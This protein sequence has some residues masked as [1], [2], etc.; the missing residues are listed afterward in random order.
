[1]S[2]DPNSSEDARDRAAYVHHLMLSALSAPGG[3]R[4]PMAGRLVADLCG[5]LAVEGEAEQVARY[6]APD[7]ADK[8][9]F[10]VRSFRLGDVHP[11]TDQ[12]SLDAESALREAARLAAGQTELVEV[13]AVG[14]NGLRRRVLDRAGRAPMRFYFPDPTYYEGPPSLVAE[15]LER[16]R[17][18]LDSGR[19]AP[20]APVAPAAPP[21]A[22][23]DTTAVAEAVRQALGDVTVEVDL[24]AVEAVVADALRS[25]LGGAGATALSLGRSGTDRQSDP[26]RGDAGGSFASEP[27]TLEQ[28]SVAVVDQQARS[29]AEAQARELA[30]RLMGMVENRLRQ[31]PAPDPILGA[32]MG[33]GQT[34][35]AEEMARAVSASIR[36]MLANLRPEEVGAGGDS[37]GAAW[38]AQA[39][40]VSAAE[41][42]HLQLEAFGDRVKSGSRA[43]EG[44]ADELN[45]RERTAAGHTDRLAQTIT[46]SL[47]R[48]GRRLEERIEDVSAAR[49]D[50]GATRE[51]RD[52]TLTLSRLV[53][54]LD[55]A[56]P[57]PASI[58]RL[59]EHP[60]A[61]GA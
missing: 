3:S 2:D 35:G 22:A 4:S 9:T 32:A 48:L 1:M 6:L 59:R 15:A 18:L 50:A 43:L 34:S 19:G 49:A 16:W 61:T 40:L 47:E 20:S 24:G 21:V 29:M 58:S 23:L 27:P 56:P 44:L 52:L 38:M 42:L 8:A 17:W 37:P 11:L 55:P 12:G 46:V 25:T 41:Q 7:P 10:Q 57:R 45:A 33:W 26:A 36:P 30:E 39:S 54:R 5:V 51:L 31:L 60:N 53:A 14:A 28:P 13:V